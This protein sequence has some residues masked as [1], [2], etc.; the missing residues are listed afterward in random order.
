MSFTDHNESCLA[1]VG[2]MIGVSSMAPL[3]AMSEAAQ[4]GR[5]SQCSVLGALVLLCSVACGKGTHS[6]SEDG[7]SGVGVSGGALAGGTG[8]SGTGGSGGTRPGPAGSGAV[9]AALPNATEHE[10]AILEPLFIPPVEIE[11]ADVAQLIEMGASIGLAR[12]YAMCRCAGV[13]TQADDI[14]GC[15]AAETGTLA[16]T[17]SRRGAPVRLLDQDLARCLRE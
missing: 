5:P 16:F 11:A 1:G 2:K 13:F 10:L 4:G 6:R 8:G 17:R 14:L 3:L 15:A 12:G 9:S 7:G